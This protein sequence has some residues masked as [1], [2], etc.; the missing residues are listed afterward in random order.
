MLILPKA[1][2]GAPLPHGLKKPNYGSKIEEIPPSCNTGGTCDTSDPSANNL[3]DNIK[4][5]PRTII[6]TVAWSIPETEEGGQFFGRGRAVMR[7][8]LELFPEGTEWTAAQ[9]GAHGFKHKVT[10]LCGT[11]ICGWLYFGADH[12][13]LWLYLT[14]AGLQCRRNEKLAD[15]DLVV[16]CESSGSKLT[17]VDI[18]LDLYD[19]QEFSVAK[20]L[21]LYV[22]EQEFYDR[23]AKPQRRASAEECDA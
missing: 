16:L 5:P 6:D 1:S 18:A 7:Q 4:N 13:K 17:R 3:N 2:R 20:A 23:V 8:V 10:L 12:E 11:L 14:G 22:A 9:A 19:H 21:Q 15:S